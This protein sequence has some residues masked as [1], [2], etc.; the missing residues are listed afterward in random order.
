MKKGSFLVLAVLSFSIL[1]AGCS[2]STDSS[3]TAADPGIYINGN[4]VDLPEEG[5]SVDLDL[6]SVEDGIEITAVKEGREKIFINGK[7]CR[8]SVE[9]DVTA[10]TRDETIEVSITEDGETADYTI[11]LMP[12]AFLDYTTEGESQTDGDYYLT[13]Y[14]EEVNYIFKL[15]NQGN[16]IFYKET[17]DNALDFRKQYNSDGEVRYTYLQYLEDGFCGIGG[18]NPGCV[19]VMDEN[20]TVID[21]LYYQTSD[22]EEIMV[23]PHGLFIWMTAIISLR[24]TKTLWSRIFRKRLRRRMTVPIWRSYISRRFRTEKFS[25]SSAVRIIRNSFMRQRMLPGMPPRK[26]AMIIC[27]LIPCISTTMTTCLFPAGISI[28]S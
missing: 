14:D 24:H 1:A 11:N 16:L 8:K 21:E 7:K 13:T 27:I 20:Y 18:I 4:Q 19:V 6:L 3:E 26:N 10:I 17:G 15:D 25:G 5:G 2:S 22:G 23:D 28:R 9:L 12:S